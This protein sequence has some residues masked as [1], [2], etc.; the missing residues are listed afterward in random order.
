MVSTILN[1]ADLYYF[2]RSENH[3]VGSKNKNN[4]ELKSGKSPRH[5]EPELNEHNKELCK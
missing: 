2:K 1:V 3:A 5:F 4:S